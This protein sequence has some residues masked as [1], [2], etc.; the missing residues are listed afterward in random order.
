MSETTTCK[1]CGA[2]IRFVVM[3][4]NKRM[5]IDDKPTKMVVLDK[6]DPGFGEVRNCYPSHFSTCPNASKHRRKP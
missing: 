1:S 4:S 6:D 3:P 2:P 5:P